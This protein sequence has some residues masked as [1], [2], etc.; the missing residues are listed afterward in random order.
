MQSF[1]EDNCW[2]ITQIHVFPR[3]KA[4]EV[5]AVVGDLDDLDV[6]HD[7]DPGL[8]RRDQRGLIRAHGRRGWLARRGAALGWRLKARYYVYQKDM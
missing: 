7:Q 8:R 1:A 3:A 6:L 4:L 5:V 2:V